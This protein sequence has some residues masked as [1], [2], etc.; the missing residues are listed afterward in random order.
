M[1]QQSWVALAN[2]VP[3][4]GA[5]TSNTFTGPQ[6]I[7]TGTTGTLGVPLTVPGNFFRVGQMWRFF[8]AGTY[9]VTGT[10]TLLFGIQIGSASQVASPAL[11]ASSGVTTMNWQ[12]DVTGTIRTIGATTVATMICS[13]RLQYQ[14]SSN[15]AAPAFLPMQAAPLAVGSGFNSTI[16]NTL[17]PYATYSA[18]SAS[19]IVV[20]HEWGVEYL[21]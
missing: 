1:A 19:N 3:P 16:A 12:F 13:G 21:N 18:S 11:T 8:A 4:I 10:P 14:A 5:I 20:M 9:S 6:D 7:S 17:T 2:D 15:T